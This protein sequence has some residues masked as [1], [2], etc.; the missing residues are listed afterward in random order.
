MRLFLLIENDDLFIHLKIPNYLYNLE[1]II[2]T[3][4][5]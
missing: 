3:D 1:K 2:Y 4:K 5:V